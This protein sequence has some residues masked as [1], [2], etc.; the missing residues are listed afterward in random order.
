M[1]TWRDLKSFLLNFDTSVQSAR[2]GWRPDT[3]CPAVCVA[4]DALHLIGG[5]DEKMDGRAM[6][7]SDSAAEEDIE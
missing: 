1:S 7:H 3:M 2:E 4:S 6:A 5:G